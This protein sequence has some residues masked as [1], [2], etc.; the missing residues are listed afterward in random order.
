MVGRAGPR[1]R[2][3]SRRVFSYLRSAR[4]LRG[5]PGVPTPTAPPTRP[6][7]FGPYLLTEC[8]GRGGTAMVYKGKRSG[9]SGFE[10][11]VV[12]K[13][14]L[15]ELLRDFRFI[16]LFNR[17]AKLSAQLFHANVA[18]VQDFGVVSGTPFLELEYLAGLNLRELWEMV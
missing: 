13:T 12:V 7:R 15:P 6:R 18:Q 16:R 4:N 10:K 1:V 3:R 17:E 5:S 2:L 11:Q 8:I 14:I 9:A